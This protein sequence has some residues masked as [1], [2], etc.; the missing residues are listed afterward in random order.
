MS[1]QMVNGLGYGRWWVGVG[2]GRIRTDFRLFLPDL[3]FS[4]RSDLAICTDK[5]YA[6]SQIPNKLKGSL[7]KTHRNLPKTTKAENLLM[8]L[9]FSFFH[10]CDSCEIL[11]ERE[12]EKE[13]RR[14]MRERERE[15]GRKKEEENEV[16]EKPR[17]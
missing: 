14:Q 2:T 12:K 6:N 13:R 1:L 17:S 10:G 7:M 15:R 8:I 3:P 16:A 4:Y 5:I 9:L 11:K